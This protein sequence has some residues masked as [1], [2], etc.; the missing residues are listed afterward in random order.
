MV[1]LFF[2]KNQKPL[3]LGPWNTRHI[4]LKAKYQCPDVC[5]STFCKKDICATA[6]TPEQVCNELHELFTGH[7]KINNIDYWLELSLNVLYIS[8]N[9]FDNQKNILV[10]PYSLKK[11]K[12]TVITNNINVIHVIAKKPRIW[13]KFIQLWLS[14]FISVYP[15]VLFSLNKNTKELYKN[16]YIN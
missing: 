11:L 9:N 13:W 2:T 12:Q 1:C 5:R 3:R 7:G 10:K 16:E 15:K 4:L 8:D 6:I 14:N